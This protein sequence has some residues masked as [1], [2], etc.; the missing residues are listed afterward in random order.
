MQGT[1]LAG[2]AKIHLQGLEQP[3]HGQ[4][5]QEIE[6]LVTSMWEV[7]GKIEAS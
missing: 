7:K 1:R 2:L 5:G 3:R 6:Y 4:K